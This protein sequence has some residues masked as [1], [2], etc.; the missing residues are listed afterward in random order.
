MRAV[1]LL[2]LGSSLVACAA[3]SAPATPPVELQVFAAASLTDGFKAAG[4]LFTRDHPKIRVTF[5]FGGTPTLLAQL[6]QGATGDLFASADQPN[7]QKAVDAGLVEGQPRVIARNKLEIVVG[8]GNPKRIGGLPDLARPDVLY[9]TEAPT[10]PAG[11]YSARALAAAGV[12]ASPKSF[13]A[14][15]KA[16]VSK[17]RLGEADAGIVYVTDVTAAGSRVAGVPIPEEQNIV[18]VYPAA[19]LKGSRHAAAARAFLDFLLS[20]GAQSAL[21]ALG[22][23]GP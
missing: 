1:A 13:E 5:N 19:A 12:K 17:V 8:A 3:P 14:D 22:F 7:M 2:M 9:I 18:A 10:V 21:R 16:V 20:P 6:E 15:V 11:K 23:L 4:E